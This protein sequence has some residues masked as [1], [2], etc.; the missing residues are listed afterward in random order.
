MKHVIRNLPQLFSCAL[1][2]LRLLFTCGKK[3]IILIGSPAHGNL[4][5]IAIAIAELDFFKPKDSAGGAA[6]IRLVEFTDLFYQRACSLLDRFILKKD[7]IWIH[8]G[9]F[10]GTLWK[11]ED[12]MANHVISTFRGNKIVVFPQT[13]YFE[14]GAD[15]AVQEFKRI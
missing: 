9:G 6:K 12:D 4:G 13:V 2:L 14:D 15:S 11:S 3:R 10:I 1:Q 7:V 8:G 5:D